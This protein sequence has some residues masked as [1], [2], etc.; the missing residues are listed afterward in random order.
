VGRAF[1][2]RDVIDIVNYTFDDLIY[3]PVG[4]CKQIAKVLAKQAKERRGLYFA[5]EYVAGAHT[6]AAC[7]SGRSIG[8]LI[9]QHWQA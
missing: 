4:Y 5:G 1:D 2:A 8:R 6:G 3:M 7:A 9:A